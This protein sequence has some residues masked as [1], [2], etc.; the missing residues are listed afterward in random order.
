MT[1]AAGL[2]PSPELSPAADPTSS[3]RR[4]APKAVHRRAARR[5]GHGSPRAA[6]PA[7]VYLL[8]FVGAPLAIVVAYSVMSR[9][10]FGVGVAA[11]F[12]LESYVRLLFDRDFDG[13][14]QFDPR[15]L[16]V[17]WNSIWLA[18][19][20]TVLCL[21]VA[22][23]TAIWMATRPTRV[24]NLLVFAITLPF[25]TNTLV[26][27]YAWMLILNDNGLA[28]WAL[29]ATGIVD[30][31]VQ[32]L[33]T[34]FATSIGLVYVFLPFMVLPIYA[35]AEKF[36]FRLAEAAYDLGARRCTVIRRVVLPAVKPG[37]IAGVALV[38]I[39]AL[40]AFLQPELLGGGRTLMLGN[41]IQQQFS[42]SRNWPFGS[43][44]AVGLLV[45]TLVVLMVFAL[46]ARRVGQKVRPM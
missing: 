36:D 37:L 42:A 35:S 44:V 17:F 27:T 19:L 23:P 6:V 16:E 13:T 2:P 22:F 45:L 12:S 34:T 46:V 21:L 25:W 40:G 5:A 38:F 18:G 28:N 9:G 33:Y 14:L 31:P 1:T 20:T 32:L 4:S 41:L 24:R 39:P 29:T 10:M 3:P 30:K 26:R 7:I 8:A 15:Y 11:D 43:A